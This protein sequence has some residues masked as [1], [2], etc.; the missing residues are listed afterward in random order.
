MNNLFLRVFIE[1]QDDMQALTVANLLEKKLMNCCNLSILKVEKY[2][3][4]P[5]YF[6]VTFDIYKEDNEI[7]TITDLIGY[8]WD[9][10]GNTYIWDIKNKQS[11]F[12][13]DKIR[14]ASLEHIV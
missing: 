4:I 9:I 1:V 11:S 5:E 7:N 2:W 12:I 3:K 14:W 6:E 10:Y 13:S 8:G